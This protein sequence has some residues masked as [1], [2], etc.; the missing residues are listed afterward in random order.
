MS[1]LT[2]HREYRELRR[3]MVEKQRA[4]VAEVAAPIA[5]ET[6]VPIGLIMGRDR[7]REVSAARHRL[8]AALWR[9]GHSVTWIAR[10]LERD[11]TTVMSGLRKA[12]GADVYKA[13]VVARYTPSRLGS[14]RGRAA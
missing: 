10:V 12:L 6:G 14:Y 8:M 7:T 11:H 5:E 3:L 1:L 2:H 9:Q 4:A 13:E